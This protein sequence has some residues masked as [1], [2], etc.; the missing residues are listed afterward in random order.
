LLLR[1]TTDKKA[2]SFTI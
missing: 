2:F 1:E